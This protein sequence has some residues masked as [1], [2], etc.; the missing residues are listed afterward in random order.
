M[1]ARVCLIQNLPNSEMVHSG[2]IETH[3]PIK[4]KILQ[5]GR[6][7]IHPDDNEVSS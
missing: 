5:N 2:E 6:F 3:F 4:Q 1:N 7:Q